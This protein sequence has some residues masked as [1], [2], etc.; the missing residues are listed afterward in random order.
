MAEF[1]KYVYALAVVALLAGLTIPVSAQTAM[2]C[3]ATSVPSNLRAEG[4]TE[5][6][7]DV[8][9]DCQGGQPTLTG[10]PVPQVNITIS[11]SVSET[12][13]ITLSSPAVIAGTPPTNFSEAIIIVDQ[14]NTTTWSNAAATYGGPRNVLNCGAPG[15]PDSNPATGFGICQILAPGSPYATYDGTPNGLPGGTTCGAATQTIGTYGC[16]RPNV[17]QGRQDLLSPIGPQQRIVFLD[18]PVDP[19]GFS[20]PGIPGQTIPPNCDAG[21]ACHRFFRITNIRVNAATLGGGSGGTVSGVPVFADITVSNENVMPLINTGTSNTLTIG[22][23]NTTIAPATGTPG[24]LTLIGCKDNNQAT[25][26]VVFQELIADAWKPR[27]ISLLLSNNTGG[28]GGT[29]YNLLAGIGT[30]STPASWVAYDCRQNVPGTNY[31]TEAGFQNTAVGGAVCPTG[32]PNP[33]PPTGLGSAVAAPTPNSAFDDSAAGGHTNIQVAGIAT[34]GTRIQLNLQNILGSPGTVDVR[35][36]GQVLLRNRANN[37]PSG[38]AILQSYAT[39]CTRR[40]C[41][42][43]LNAVLLPANSGLFPTSGTFADGTVSIGQFANNQAGTGLCTTSA[44]VAI[45]GSACSAGRA[46]YEIVFADPGV[47]EIMTVP[48]FVVYKASVISL[49]PP[50]TPSPITIATGMGYAPEYS[51]SAPQS[52]ATTASLP[53]AGTGWPYPRFIPGVGNPVQLFSI[54]GKCVCDLLF[55]YV[56]DATILPGSAFD[57]GIAIA[58]T[59]RDPGSVQRALGAPTSTLGTFGF[60]TANTPPGFTGTFSFSGGG[61]TSGTN[62]TGTAVTNE[63]TGPVQFWYYST[64]QGAG[65]PNFGNLG[66]GNQGNTQCTNVATPGQCNAYLQPH[67]S[68]SLL[69]TGTNVPAGGVLGTSSVKNVQHHVGASS[70]VDSFG[71]CRRS[72]AHL[73]RVHRCAGLVPILPRCCF[74]QHQRSGVDHRV[75]D[76]VPELSGSRA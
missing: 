39:T 14:P 5:L 44:G 55:P 68:A 63:Q 12:S 69:N 22:R 70:G 62:F 37:N 13:K 72:G 56:T 36:P 35:I 33:N 15:A 18:V 27:N 71:C 34:S 38:V 31:E 66:N 57:T 26:S 60:A 30:N 1:R 32:I 46:F 47:Q 52:F 9:I 29:L 25:G 19:P 53:P 45:P 73:H 10:S 6:A 41:R 2:V 42:R 7:G 3:T 8:I 21:G 17:F 76:S 48:F 4:M 11:T 51:N 16:G 61:T 24:T 28:A 40:A 65:S 67:W 74:R 49:Q 20:G 54:S 50:V 58:N 75:D 59:S 43:R 64:Q 23:V